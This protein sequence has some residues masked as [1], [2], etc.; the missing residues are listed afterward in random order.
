MTEKNLQSVMA[1]L[2]APFPVEDIYWKPQAMTRDRK[3]ALAV[4]YADGRA[5]E[6]CLNQVVPG[7]W[8]SNVTFTP[9]PPKIVCTATLTVCGITRTGDGEA[10]LSDENAATGAY[11]QAF[12]RAAM[13]FGLGRY[14]YDL[15]SPWVAYDQEHKR[16]PEVALSALRAS[17]ARETGLDGPSKKP[18]A[19]K[20]ATRS[21]NGDGDKD[22]IGRARTYRLDYGRFDGSTLGQLL[23]SQE[24]APRDY[25]AWLAGQPVYGEDENAPQPLRDTEHRQKLCAAAAYLY[26]NLM[27]TAQPQLA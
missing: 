10:S 5:Y 9:A 24:A 2:A 6:D 25:M 19:A 15:S 20:P 18:S 4:P 11:A 17:Y 21:G 8:A 26:L 23:D 12:K 13:R 27:A 7:D 16:F 1:A 14:L 22:T 3:K